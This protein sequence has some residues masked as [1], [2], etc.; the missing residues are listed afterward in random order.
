MV[1]MDLQTTSTFSAG[2]AAIATACAIWVAARDGRWRKGGLAKAM[3]DRITRAQTTAENWHETPPHLELRA[4][5]ERQASLL[6]MHTSRLD[7]VATQADISRLDGKLNVV[8]ASTKHTA[9]GVD[10]IEGLLMRRALDGKT[11]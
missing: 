4:E 10:R 8:A 11:S 1:A 5:V 2:C 6:I 3:E 7:Q 9:A